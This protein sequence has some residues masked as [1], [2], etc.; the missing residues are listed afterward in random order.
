[1]IEIIANFRDKRLIL[2]V[3]PNDKIETIL[4]KEK[5]MFSIYKNV[6]SGRYEKNKIKLVVTYEGIKVDENKTFSEV[7]IKN[8]SNIHI[9][10][11]DDLIGAG[12][13]DNL[14]DEKAEN[15]G[16]D[17]NLIKRNKLFINLIYYDLNITSKENYDYYINFKI[18]VVGGFYAIDNIDILK[19][20]LDTIQLKNIPFIVIS[21]GS[22]GKEVINLCLKYLFVKEVII[23][24]SNYKYNKHYLE[25]YPGYVKK[26]FT[27]IEPIYDYLKN[28]SF[29]QSAKGIENY[30]TYEQ[31]KMDR[32]I[33]QCPLI[34]S[35]E[36]D[37]CYFLVHRAYS[38]F[39]GNMLD[40]KNPFHDSKCLNMTRILDY[41]FQYVEDEDMRVKFFDIFKGLNDFQL[42]NNIFVE[43]A[44]RAYTGESAFCY[45]FNRAMRD[46]FQGLTLIAYFMGPFLFG[47]N[48]YVKDNP[49]FAF[50]KNMTLY[51]N[52]S[53]KTID[54][55]L[56]KLNLNHIVCFPSITSTS[57][58]PKEFE[59]SKL[60]NKINNIN[61]DDNEII[62]IKMIFNYK[63]KSENKSPGIIIED[64][65]GY[66]G[67]YISKHPQE[68]E[69]ILFPFTF[70]KIVKI[71]SGLEKG[72]EIKIIYFDIIN[73]E[74]YIEY[75]L[76]DN[77][78]A[79]VL[80]NILED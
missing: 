26:V 1:M 6:Y 59:P 55:Y 52:I 66:D 47:L 72:K 8:Y 33:E 38:H 30:F 70:A 61:I 24:C 48:K 40:D 71:E 7:G 16:F 12:P 73:R 45:M 31:I 18:D 58:K 17:L 36:Y 64:K 20:Y 32:Q 44:I 10:R 5:E 57:S 21:T 11:I 68:N 2:T 14:N 4:K 78:N 46:F 77:V 43:K 62:K 35:K 34:V 13:I 23:F 22:S 49:S 41:C 3:N 50:S 65:K 74:T 37:Q 79:R 42:N 39:F 60:A 76:K 75:V 27:D 69:V 67:K 29:S 9:I 51:R 19:K 25:D 63:H 15:L 80:F 28:F 53:C 56:Y 54:F